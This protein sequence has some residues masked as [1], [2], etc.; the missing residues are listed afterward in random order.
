MSCQL[1]LAQQYRPWHFWSRKVHDS[2][3][4]NTLLSAVALWFMT[5]S[6]PNTTQ[7]ILAFHS[8]NTYI[9]VKL[10]VDLKNSKNSPFHTLPTL[11]TSTQYIQLQ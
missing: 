2:F 6:R 8:I 11:L 1:P 7:N 5:L 10:R 9:G 4:L 3:S